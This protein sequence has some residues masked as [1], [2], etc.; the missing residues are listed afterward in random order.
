MIRS[1]RSIPTSATR[2]KGEWI[3]EFSDQAMA[4]QGASGLRRKLSKHFK[5][6]F[7]IF[8]HRA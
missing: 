6:C 5:I 1:R 2:G 7:A 3:V 8:D 4:R